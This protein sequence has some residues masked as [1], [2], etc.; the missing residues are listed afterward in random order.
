MMTAADVQQ[1]KRLI[2]FSLSI[3]R[4]GHVNDLSAYAHNVPMPDLD[5]IDIAAIVE[6]KNTVIVKVNFSM[7]IFDQVFSKLEM[8]N[9]LEYLSGASEKHKIP[10][11]F[12]QTTGTPAVETNF[13]YHNYSRIKEQRRKNRTA[14]KSILD[15]GMSSDFERFTPKSEDRVLKISSGDLFSSEEFLDIL[16]DE[17]RKT[18]MLTGF[19]TELEILRTS[20]SSMEHG[21][22]GVTVSDATSTYSERIY[23]E[24]LDLI[25]QSTEVIDT[26]DLMKIWP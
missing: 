20:A 11:L 12:V 23:Y 21:Y 13:Q 10:Q 6:P 3:P 22:Y 14:P 16:R 9:A 18:C 1:K 8:I 19:F 2:C 26:R 5:E 25:S 7:E 24:A 15:S 4:N 17:G